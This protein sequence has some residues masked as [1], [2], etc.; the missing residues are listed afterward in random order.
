MADVRAFRGFRYDA[1][2]VGS[3]ADV[4]CPPY[5]VIDPGLQRSL[6][7]K[8]PFNAVR[9]E[10]AADEPGDTDANSKYTRA[11]NALRDWQLAR[12]LVQDTARSLYVY[13]QEFTAAG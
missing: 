3:F 13:E 6:Y 1:G 7:A 4:V 9:V 5:D 10:L 11:A 8:S 2:K 12:A